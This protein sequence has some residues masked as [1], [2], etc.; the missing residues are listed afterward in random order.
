MEEHLVPILSIEAVTHD[1]NRYRVE[2]PHDYHFTPGQATEVAI[3]KDG[4]R[5]EKR[6]F[7]FTSL[8]EEEELEFTIKSYI[9]HQGVTAQLATLEAGDEL[10]LHDIWGAI[11]YKG[12][13]VFIAGGAGITPFIAIFRQLEKQG[14]IKGNSL[15]FSNKTKED[16]ILE[17]YWK[18]LLGDNFIPVLTR[19]NPTGEKQRIDKSFL[20]KHISNFDQHFYICGPEK[21]IE[22]LQ[23][24]LEELGAKTDQLVFE[25]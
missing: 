23:K 24:A 17:D 1:V 10:L 16:I 11:K 25:E 19:E 15:I 4:C 7:T 3:N 5:E 14:K 21:M 18:R 9:S 13:G 6:P 2:K 22:D 12:P 8:N 20:Q